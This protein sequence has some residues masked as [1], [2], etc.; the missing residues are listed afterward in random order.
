M[1][2]VP[3]LWPLR[4]T[5]RILR[6]PLPGSGFH[7]LEEEAEAPGKEAESEHSKTPELAGE[8]VADRESKPS[9]H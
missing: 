6:L 5:R 2:P 7:R 9:S 1:R 8:A 4:P 3:L